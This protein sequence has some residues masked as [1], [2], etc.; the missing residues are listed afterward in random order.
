MMPSSNRTTHVLLTGAGGDQSVFIWKA[1]KQSNLD[2]RIVACDSNYLA[3]GLYR[4]ERG[5]VI[6]HAG[7]DEYLPRLKE[8]IVAE[9]IDMVM[10]GGREEMMLLAEHAQQIQE[11]TGAYVV[12]PH[13]DTLKIAG[14]KW[15]LVA[16][17]KAHGFSYP[18]SCIPGD[19]SDFDCFLREVDFPYIV[20]GRFGAGSRGLA[21]AHDRQELEHF[22]DQVQSPIIQEYLLPDDEEYTVGCFCNSQAQAVGSIV[23]KRT[24]GH[25]LTNKASVVCDESISRYC[26]RI[27]EKLGYIG[28]L[29]LQLRLTTRG[30][31]LFE[32]NPR[33]SSTESARAYFNFNM[34][35][36]CIRH[37][38]FHE[39][40]PRPVINTGYFFRVFDDVF[41]D[42]EAIEETRKT[43]VSN[44][45]SGILI[46]N[47]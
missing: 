11:E 31:V 20:K 9:K 13:F 37:F 22:I 45:V 38:L 30:P 28:P 26:E 33:F 16:F 44:G 14:D 35:E 19:P 18:R 1:L 12:A 4:T 23:M 15:Q 10:T 34:P 2:I 42:A 7:S 25:G 29:N 27:S 6:P 39:E 8:I 24:L 40:I 32:I 41:V 5:Y 36:M 17:L 3:V 47:F 43:G 46:P 21:V